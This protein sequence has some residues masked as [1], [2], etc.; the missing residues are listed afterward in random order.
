[1]PEWPDKFSSENVK[2]IW[3]NRPGTA[4]WLAMRET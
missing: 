4:V 1:M 2:A 3:T